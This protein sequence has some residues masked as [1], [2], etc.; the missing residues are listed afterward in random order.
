MTAIRKAWI[1]FCFEWARAWRPWRMAMA[2]GLILFPPA[3]LGLVQLKGAQLQQHDGWIIMAFFLIPEMVSILGTLLLATTALHGEVEGRT[4]PYL[5]VRPG[6]RFPILLGKY[7]AA[8]TW[9]MLTGIASAALAVP[10]VAPAGRG[11]E[12]FWFISA[13]VALSCLANGAIFL[14]CGAMF[15]RRAMIAAVVYTFCIEFVIGLIP[16]LINRITVQYHLRTLLFEWFQIRFSQARVMEIVGSGPA[17][18]HAAIL[19]GMSAL[20]LSL[21]WLA[22]RRRQLVTAADR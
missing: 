13:L 12:G 11:V 2:A 19:L 14:F 8:V 5:T 18:H 7:F 21:T 15:L 10:I 17:W 6:G 16:A 20:L 1:V 22:V 9:T 3:L 4:W